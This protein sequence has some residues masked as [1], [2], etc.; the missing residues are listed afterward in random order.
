[1]K[2]RT[3]TQHTEHLTK[4]FEEWKGKY[5]RALADYQNLEKRMQA[6]RQGEA[7]F[8]AKNLIIKIL[9]VLDTLQKAD[10]LLN[11]QGLKLALKQLQD[12][13]T[14]EGIEKIQVID[15][16]FDP[17]AMECFE[18]VESDKENEVIEEV[19]AGYTMFGKVVRVAQVKVGKK[20]TDN[21]QQLTN[22]KEQKV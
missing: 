18:V 1:M 14:S 12:T 3:D 9:P 6:V 16:K 8:A 10:K 20:T 21:R 11:D 2:K 5:L 13:L 4:E 22:N 7:R 15:K 19:R 17:Q